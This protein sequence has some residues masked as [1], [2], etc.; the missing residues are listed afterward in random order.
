MANRLCGEPRGGVALV[1][2]FGGFWESYGLWT[3]EFITGDTLDR[4]L[5]RLSRRPQEEERY[6]T[7][8][9]HAAWSGLALF[10]D[11]WNRTGR[12]LVVADPTSDKRH[13]PD[14]RLSDRRTA[15]FDRLAPVVYVLGLNAAILP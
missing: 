3:E 9:P 2:N 12:R 8:W 5:N 1:Q 11:F 7:V 6:L 14:A 10:V 13:R 15:G 4:A